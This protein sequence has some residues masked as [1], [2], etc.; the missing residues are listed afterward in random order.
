MLKKLIEN[1][2][3]HEMRG[4]ADLKRLLARDRGCFAFFHGA[5]PDD[6]LVFVEDALTG[7]LTTDIDLIIGPDQ[8]EIDPQDANSAIFYLINNRHEGQKGISFGN[9]LINQV[10]LGM[11]RKFP[12]LDTYATLSPVPC[13]R[14]WLEKTAGRDDDPLT[15]EER[16]PVEALDREGWHDDTALGS[17]LKPVLER[18]IAHNLVKAKRGNDPLNPVARFHLRNGVRIEQINWL[19]DHSAGRLFSRRAFPSIMS[20]IPDRSSATARTT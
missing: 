3:V 9:F 2:N 13:F 11:A 15:N 6:L 7:G 17:E 20:T 19:G 16:T 5:L 12:K 1:K 14:S 8:M 18:K 4:W 10:V